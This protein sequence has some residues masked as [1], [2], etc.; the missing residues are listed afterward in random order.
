MC[1]T[2]LCRSRL[3]RKCPY[4]CDFELSVKLAA[5]RLPDLWDTCPSALA[6]SALGF[7]EIPGFW[8]VAISRES[9][10]IRHNLSVCP[11]IYVVDALITC[12]WPKRRRR[13][14]RSWA[15]NETLATF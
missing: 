2:I 11:Y 4:G 3:V 8:I 5:A 12:R 13:A 9:V 10:D 6:Y 14:L 15:W 7:V 1:K